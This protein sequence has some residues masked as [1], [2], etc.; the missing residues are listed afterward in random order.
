MKRLPVFI[1][2]FCLM[3]FSCTELP[4]ANPQFLIDNEKP[5][6]EN[7]IRDI[8]EPSGFGRVALNPESF[9]NWL[10]N[11]G[12]KKDK[13]VYL[14]DGRK[15]PNQSAQYAVLDISIGDKDLQQCADAVMR[16]RAEYFYELGKLDQI[17]FFNGKREKLNYQK[18]L[19]NKRNSRKD[20]MKYMEYVFSYCG[21]ASLP[22]SVKNKALHQIQIGDILLKPGSPGH[23]VMVMDMA[24]KQNGK[25]VYLLAQSYMPAQSIHILNN[26]MNREISPWY[27]LNENPVIN[28]PEWTFYSNQL[29]GWK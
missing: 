7:M 2:I 27:E 19:G 8:K 25:K 15:K 16:L 22:Y 6:E 12:L 9:S 11:R 13:T 4:D 14:Y 23:T 5:V 21:T 29:Y 26:P 17:E 20:F 24:K 18:W 28:T 10:R 1:S 3:L